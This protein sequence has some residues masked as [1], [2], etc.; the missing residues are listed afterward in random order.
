MASADFCLITATFAV[1]TPFLRNAK[2]SRSPRIRTC[3]RAVALRRASVN[4]RYTTEVFTTSPESVGLRHVVLTCPDD[5]RNYALT[6]MENVGK[7]VLLQI[8]FRMEIKI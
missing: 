8:N 3:L 4:C 6:M 7:V 1:A 5:G 2:L